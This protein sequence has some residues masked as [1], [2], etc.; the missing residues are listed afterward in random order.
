MHNEIIDSNFLSLIIE[1]TLESSKTDPNIF[2][3]GFFKVDLVNP[4]SEKNGISVTPA[5]ITSSPRILVNPDT[6][7]K[8]LLQK[9]TTLLGIQI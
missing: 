9:K 3:I 6:D 5:L 4:A 2:S 8:L 1:A 7:L